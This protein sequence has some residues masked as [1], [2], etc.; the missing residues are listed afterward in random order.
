ML[1]ATLCKLYFFYSGL[2]TKET[3]S[4]EDVDISLMYA[5]LREEKTFT[6]P[7]N[8]WGKRPKESDIDE[9]DDIERIR[10]YRNLICHLDAS[11]METSTFNESVLDL[12]GVTYFTRRLLE[13]F[14]TF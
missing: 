2:K 4:L 1:I 10:Y 11:N 8:G 14:S 13:L 5:I 12:L 9:A 6:I 7:K 3:K